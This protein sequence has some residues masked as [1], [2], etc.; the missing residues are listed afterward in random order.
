VGIA[1]TRDWNVALESSVSSSRVFLGD[2]GNDQ[3]PVDGYAVANLRSSYRLT[4]ALELFVRIDNLY[5]TDYETFG[6]LA[7]IE[8]DLAEVPG[9]DDPRFLSPGAPRSGFAGIRIQF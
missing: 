9:A 3:V 8:I 1:M 7:E 5:N 4:D 2:E 6:L